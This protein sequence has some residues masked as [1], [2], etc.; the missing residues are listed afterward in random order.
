MLFYLR[1]NL[2]YIYPFHNQALSSLVMYKVDNS[3]N[4]EL[5]PVDINLFYNYNYEFAIK[6]NQNLNYTKQE[7]SLYGRSKCWV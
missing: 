4:F 7:F 1:Q 5:V 6:R 2:S 3:Y